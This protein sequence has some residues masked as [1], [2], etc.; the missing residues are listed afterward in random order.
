MK[1]SRILS[2]F[3][4]SVLAITCIALIIWNIVKANGKNVYAKTINFVTNVGS[5]EIYKENSLLIDTSMVKVSPSNCNFD[6]EFTIKKYNEKDEDAKVVDIGKYKFSASGK[7]ILSCRVKS[8]K[9][10]Y[11]KDSILVTVV[12]TPSTT[13][14][15]YIIKK[16]SR[17]LYV[18]EVIDVNT[19][20]EISRTTTAKV[21]FKCSEHLVVDNEKIKVVKE[22][23]GSIEVS[24]NYEN[25]VIT[26]IIY[27]SIQ[28]KI[29]EN[30]IELIL[31]LDGTVI[32]NNTFEVEY[33]MFVYI[34]NYEI[35]PL[36]NNQQITCWTNSDIIQITSYNSPTIMFNTLG[37][38]KAVIYVSSVEYPS[39]VFEIE[40]NII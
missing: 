35:Y 8:S 26:D 16:P 15:M 14:Q 36:Y 5:I 13:T 40:I 39:I 24:I 7:Y 27:F 22:G 31:S 6:V 38:G 17:F 19:L 2:I 10:Y 28:P 20:A 33:S 11:I 29:V 1:R 18:D 12:N 25:I 34:L 4:V 30:E 21:D 23:T 32:E 37:V 9:D 3:V